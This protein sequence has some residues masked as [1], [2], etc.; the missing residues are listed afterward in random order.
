[1]AGA[2]PPLESVD[3]PGSYPLPDL[4]VL[5][6]GDATGWGHPACA[7]CG[8]LVLGGGRAELYLAGYAKEHGPG[9][10]LTGVTAEFESPVTDGANTF[11]KLKRGQLVP[12]FSGSPLLDQRT[13]AV[14]AIAESSR[15]TGTELGGFAVPADVL[16]KAFPPVA[17]A[18][19]EFHARDKRWRDAA[20]TERVLAAE[21]AKLRGQPPPWPPV[22]EL[23]PEEA[24]NGPGQGEQTL[25]DL[26]PR[27]AARTIWRWP[28]IIVS[29][30]VIGAVI[31][32][33]VMPGTPVSRP[34]AKPGT[35]GPPTASSRGNYFDCTARH[36]YS[37]AISPSSMSGSPYQGARAT[38]YLTYMRSGSASPSNPAHINSSLW[39]IQNSARDAY[40][41]VGIY[42][43]WVGADSTRICTRNN[44]HPHCIHFIYERGNEGSSAC[45]NN[46]CAAY[47]IYWADTNTSGATENTF[48]HIV[49]FTSPSPSTQ[50]YVDDG[51]NQGEW[52]VHII[53]SGLNYYGTST[54]N[55][56]YQYVESIK[57]GGE[58]DQVAKAGACA[59]IESMTFAMWVPPET[60]EAFDAQAPTTAHVD[61]STFNGTQ[62][63]PGTNL[64]TWLWSVPTTSNYNGC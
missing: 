38:M 3:D 5:E 22:V 43:G 62:Q 9:P 2:A 31:A 24:V 13:Q 61:T 39:V 48:F 63:V 21:R 36:C 25:G 58:L 56:R 59:D 15:G 26:R 35:T 57:I 37:I 55:S 14:A 54:L 60:Y 10:V 28:V 33:N 32:I 17:R 6:V 29:I 7:G 40:M 12:G 23:G 4:A 52:K 1:M 49:E 47:V 20:N 45:I 50:L 44:S 51:Y 34:P 30:I 8:P 64:G 41:E 42:D 18:S 53:S 11:F 16:V 19:Q 46:G 27:R